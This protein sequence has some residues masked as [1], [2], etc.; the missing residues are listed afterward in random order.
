MK[1]GEY[2]IKGNV[3]IIDRKT[4][5]LIGEEIERDAD[6]LPMDKLYDILLP[7]VYNGIIKYGMKI[8]KISCEQGEALLQE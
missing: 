2:M 8:G 6:D 7:Q 3:G 5:E 1:G 4:G